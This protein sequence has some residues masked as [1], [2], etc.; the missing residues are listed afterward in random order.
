MR[1]RKIKLSVSLVAIVKWLLMDS[2]PTYE[3]LVSSASY[4]FLTG[5]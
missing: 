3:I 4:K 5:H 2:E 1:M